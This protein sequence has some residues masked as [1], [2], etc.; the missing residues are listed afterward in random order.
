MFQKTFDF[1]GNWSES[2]WQVSTDKLACRP[3]GGHGN[4][5]ATKAITRSIFSLIP[6]EIR[7]LPFTQ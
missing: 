2:S 7:I 3:T 5:L 4:Q 6:S 1:A